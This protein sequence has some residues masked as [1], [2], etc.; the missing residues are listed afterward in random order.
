VRALI[1]TAKREFARTLPGQPLTNQMPRTDLLDE[2]TK[3][4]RENEELRAELAARNAATPMLRVT[5]GPIA[6]DGGT[7]RPAA[8]PPAVVPV[9]DASTIGLAPMQA[10]PSVERAAPQS[11]SMAT[12]GPTRVPPLRPDAVP[13]GRRHVVASGDTLF[14]LTQKYYG[15]SSTAKA[16]AIFEANRDVM[17][18]ETD[19]KPGMELKIP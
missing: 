6:S 9:E 18:S 7:M 1:D 13:A 14:G 5:R 2:L 16:R 19:L 4:Q 15:T 11:H 12:P 8:A 10:A 3:L 17:K